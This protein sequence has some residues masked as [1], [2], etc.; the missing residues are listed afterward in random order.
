M[1][2]EDQIRTKAYY[3]WLSEGCPIGREIDHWR[4]ASK[5]VPEGNGSNTPPA[6]P[7]ASP[8]LTNEGPTSG[9]GMLPPVGSNDPN[10]APSG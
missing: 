5:L 4:R 3:L 6:G 10:Q 7:H 2:R 8:E 9:T 1:S